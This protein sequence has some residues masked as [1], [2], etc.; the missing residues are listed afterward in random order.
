MRIARP[1]RRNDPT[2]RASGPAADTA[3]T[4]SP[5]SSKMGAGM[6]RN[7][8]ALPLVVDSEARHPRALEVGP[9]HL[10]AFHLGEIHRLTFVLDR[11]M[12]DLIRTAGCQLDVG[13]GYMTG[14]KPWAFMYQGSATK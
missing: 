3:A 14:P 6:Q 9:H 4:T 12:D 7:P 8:T 13:T 10:P 5:V 1:Q 2:I 11:K